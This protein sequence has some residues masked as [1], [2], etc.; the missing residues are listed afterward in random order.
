MD[1]N[2]PGKYSLAQSSSSLCKPKIATFIPPG[3][4][5]REMNLVKLMERFGDD[6]K[7]R[8]YIEELRWPTGVSCPR[9]DGKSISKIEE[10]SQYE[11]FL[12]TYL[13]IERPKGNLG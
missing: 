4:W 12:A 1:R 7:C 11:W 3:R 8:D 10:R 9:C 13:M 6:K 5:Y 2:R